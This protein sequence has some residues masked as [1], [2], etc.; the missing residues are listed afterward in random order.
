[1]T[2]QIL[3]LPLLLL[4]SL[5]VKAND[6]ADSVAI[7]QKKIEIFID[8]VN[9]SLKYRTGQ[10]KPEDGNIQL[11]VPAGF[12]YLNK[13]QS[14]FVLTKLWGNP[15]SAA[16]EVIGM[17]FPENAGPFT[18]S[19][20]AFVISYS[21][22]G[23]I[24]DEDAGKINYDQLL[25]DLQSEEKEENEKRVKAGY[26]AINLVGWAQKPFYDEQRKIL[27]WAKELRVGGDDSVNTLNYQ[28]R[29][30]GRKGM[31]SLNAVGK[32]Y[33]L[34]LV[35]KDISKVLGIASF[36]NGNSY[37]DFNPK[38][39]KVAA[40]TIGGLVAGKLLAK[41]GLF[42]IILKFLAPLWKGI[43][44]FF[45]AIGA[46]FKKRLGR[47]SDPGI[48]EYTPDQPADSNPAE[49]HQPEHQPESTQP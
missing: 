41:A 46:W 11:D 44:I 2:R 30:L 12:K 40:W 18:D 35:N 34:P 32:M 23:H 43:V 28:I 39:D 20:F 8:S 15:E 37:K 1:M 4:V 7:R 16:D 14:K 42:A 17:L 48:Q 19:S 22:T 36:T 10:V 27:H 49:E 9:S 29:I 26:P 3:T 24:K 25:K 5:C 31:V 6:P 45:V 47:K 13:Q 33:E 21:E 38:I